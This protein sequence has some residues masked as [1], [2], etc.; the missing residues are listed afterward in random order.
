MALYIL[1]LQCVLPGFVA[2]AMTG[3][4]RTSLMVASP[5]SFANSALNSVGHFKLTAGCIP[6]VMQ[7][8]VRGGGGCPHVQ[9]TSN[10]W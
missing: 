3:I 1:F 2:T 9:N 7:V 6:H 4:K 8:R 5:M 10:G